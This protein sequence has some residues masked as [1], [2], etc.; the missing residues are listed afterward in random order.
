MTQAEFPVE[1]LAAVEPDARHKKKKNF[2]MS[3]S[4]G[5]SYVSAFRV[6]RMMYVGLVNKIKLKYV[7]LGKVVACE[8]VFFF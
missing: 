7:L 4:R 6:F 2:S 1:H 5:F 8:F 3:H